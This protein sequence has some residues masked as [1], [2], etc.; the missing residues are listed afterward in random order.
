M[1]D[2]E[3]FTEQVE[4]IKAYNDLADEA[5]KDRPAVIICVDPITGRVVTSEKAESAHDSALLCSTFPK[6]LLK[7][8]M[9]H[10]GIPLDMAIGALHSAVETCGDELMQEM[11]QQQA[12]AQATGVQA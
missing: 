2:G 7:M 12:I 4:F 1:T 3:R 10:N 9:K 11:M 8:L 6:I 5:W